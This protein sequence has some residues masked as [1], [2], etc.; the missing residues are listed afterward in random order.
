MPIIRTWANSWATSE[1]YKET[2]RLPCIFGCL[3]A[4]DELSHYI[5][6]EV[7]WTMIAACTGSRLEDL[8]ITDAQKLC[9]CTP[10]LWSCKRLTVAFSVY[11]ALRIGHGDR[12]H[13]LVHVQNFGQIHELL[14]EHAAWFARE[15][16]IARRHPSQLRTNSAMAASLHCSGVELR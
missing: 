14:F 2:H 1:R 7:L 5:Q 11:H 9:W 6:C 16:G 3:N 15:Q 4:R 8:T 13:Q 10:S 12:I